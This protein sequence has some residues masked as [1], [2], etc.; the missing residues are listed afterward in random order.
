MQ[1][2]PGTKLSTMADTERTED[3]VS[4]SADGMVEFFHSID[5]KVDAMR[6]QRMRDPETLGDK[7]FKSA[8]PALAGLIGGKLFQLIWN[9]GLSRRGI[10]KDDDHGIV[11]SMVFAVA[12]AAI[13]ALI[14]EAS[15]RGSQAVIDKRHNMKRR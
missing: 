1:G 7:L 2:M 11:L 4:P 8:V 3:S 10:G 13:G 15:T 5:R 14:S 9:K 12:S 6:E